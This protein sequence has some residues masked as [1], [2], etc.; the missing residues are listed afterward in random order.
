MKREIKSI[1]YWV[2]REIEEVE[3]VLK[4]IPRDYE[5][6]NNVLQS[7]RMEILKYFGDIKSNLEFLNKKAQSK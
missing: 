6:Q 5:F 2:T 4:K 7:K 1:H 3:E